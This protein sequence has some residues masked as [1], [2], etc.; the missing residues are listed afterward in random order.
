MCFT[1]REFMLTS[2]TSGVVDELGTLEEEQIYCRT[3]DRDGNEHTVIGKCIIFVRSFG[4]LVTR[5]S[6]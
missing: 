6:S 4:P 3:V 1:F 5:S 2:R